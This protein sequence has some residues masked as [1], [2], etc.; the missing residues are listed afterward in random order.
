MRTQA[1]SKERDGEGF[2]VSGLGFRRTQAVSKERDGEGSSRLSLNPHSGDHGSVGVRAGGAA[3]T[4]FLESQVSAHLA[5][6]LSPSQ[7][8]N[9]R[10]ARKNTRLTLSFGG[11]LHFREAAQA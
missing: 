3:L 2:R 6:T 4:R 9:T 10:L 8:K 11:R 7:D 5:R 1:A